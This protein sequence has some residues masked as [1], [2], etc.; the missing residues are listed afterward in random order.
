MVSAGC[1]HSLN[2]LCKGVR[3]FHVVDNTFRDYRSA[4]LA[5]RGA[6][7]EWADIGQIELAAVKRR[8]DGQPRGFDLDL[9]PIKEFLIRCPRRCIWQ[10]DLS[11]GSRAMSAIRFSH[12]LIDKPYV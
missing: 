9:G 8:S 4:R 12:H 10:S 1:R 3:T 7:W 11:N 6:A 2:G 5:N